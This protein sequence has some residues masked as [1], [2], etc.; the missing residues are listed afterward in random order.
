[1]AKITTTLFGEL[2]IIPFQAEAPISETLEFYTDVMLA[3]D[4]T[5]KRLQL[6]HFRGKL[7]NTTFR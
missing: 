5:E 6:G 3:S 1:M 7:S 2:A 4:G